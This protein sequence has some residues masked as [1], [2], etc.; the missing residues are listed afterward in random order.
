LENHW[1][2]ILK[3]LLLINCFVL[4]NA[5]QYF[6]LSLTISKIMIKQKEIFAISHLYL[7]YSIMRLSLCVL[8][9]KT[10]K[11]FVRCQ[12]FK[13]TIIIFTEF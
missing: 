6:K 13:V 4:N 5:N 2:P 8:V 9:S 7:N 3:D 1:R 12:T 11:V 10:F